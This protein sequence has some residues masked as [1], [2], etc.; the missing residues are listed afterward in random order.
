MNHF[1]KFGCD[2]NHGKEDL[3]SNP[4]P[5]ILCKVKQSLLYSH[6]RKMPPSVHG[7]FLPLKRIPSGN[8]RK[9]FSK[10]DVNN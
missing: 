5:E 6:K 1:T 3:N 2:N 9:V 7:I 10:M 4:N 8:T